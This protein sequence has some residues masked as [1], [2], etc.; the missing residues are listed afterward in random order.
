MSTAARLEELRAKVE[1][2]FLV[3]DPVNVRYLT[4]FKSSNPALLVTPDGAQL[5]SDFRYAEAGR[6]IEGVEFVEV[7]RTMVKV[8]AERLEG[9]VGFEA[10]FVTYDGYET[11]RSGGAELV[12]RKD[13]VQ[14]LRAVKDEAEI[15]TI[16]RAAEITDEVYARFAKEPAVGK[17]EAELAWRIEQL[18]RECGADGLS[19]PVIVAT[20]PNGARPHA[21]PGERVLEPGQLVVVDS[22]CTVDGYC[23]DC[24]RTFSTGS[25]PGELADAYALCLEAQRTGLEAVRAGVTGIDADAAARSVIADAGLGEAFGHGLGHGVGLEIHEAPRLSRESPD[26]LRAGQIVT[27]EPG[28][29][30]E[31][32]GGVRIE[33]LTVVRD[34]GVEI[35]S[36]FTKDLVELG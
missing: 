12:P 8:L 4:G 9:R 18:F 10:D 14:A 29:Y 36:H 22:G 32:N 3:L 15:G 28:I 27:V 26:A 17:S 7:T 23:S 6:A 21:V 5:F 1:E 25:L 34:D 13:V 19:F 11:L 35:L 2:P 16:R 30:L 33:D 20:G 31:G 24:T